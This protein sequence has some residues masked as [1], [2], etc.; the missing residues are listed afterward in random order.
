LVFVGI[1]GF[2]GSE[3]FAVM[4]A[5]LL[6]LE[7]SSLGADSPAQPE[8]A[9]AL[10]TA[11]AT[12]V[13]PIDLIFNFPPDAE[14]ANGTTKLLRPAVV[15]RCTLNRRSPINKPEVGNVTRW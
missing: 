6:A 11:T 3:P 10:A 1:S 7:D 5:E 12:A 15:D 4:I 9:S 14:C 13:T 2:C 8:S